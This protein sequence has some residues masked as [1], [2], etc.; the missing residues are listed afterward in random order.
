[1]TRSKKRGKRTGSLLPDALFYDERTGRLSRPAFQLLIELNQQFDGFNN[2]NLCAAR[3]CLRFEWNDKTLK[4]AKRDLI[5]EKLIEVTRRGLGRKPTLY[6]LCHLPINECEKHG[7][8]A[9]I[10]CNR[11]ADG[12]RSHYYPYRL[13]IHGELKQALEKS[14]ERRC[15]ID[16]KKAEWQEKWYQPEN[17]AG[18]SVPSK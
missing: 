6:A 11:R 14:A 7:I 3:K 18:Y 2:G 12:K 4:A 17:I 5:H 16:E 15:Q 10:Q 9:E 1:M 13:D 8:K